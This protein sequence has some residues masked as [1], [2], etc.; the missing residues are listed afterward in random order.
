M[1]NEIDTSKVN[2]R[3][4][5]VTYAEA[6]A[7]KEIA[8]EMDTQVIEPKPEP[9]EIEQGNITLN[10]IALNEL[11]S[12]GKAYPDNAKVYYNPL[13]FGDMKFLSGSNLGV[14]ESMDFFLKHI[15]TNFDKNDITYFDFYYIVVMIKI[16]TYGTSDYNINFKCSK[17]NNNIKKEFS[18]TD[19]EFE[20]L[21][22]PLPATIKREKVLEPEEP[23]Y[24]HFKPLTIG[25]YRQ[26]LDSGLSG[27]YDAYMA[28]QCSN[29]EMDKA[30]E[31]IKEELSGINV[32]MLESI[33]ELFFHG[34]RDIEV[35]CQ[36][37][38]EPEDFNRDDIKEGDFIDKS[39]WEVCGAPH[40]L[41]FQSLAGYVSATAKVQESIRDRIN[42]GL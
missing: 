12:G 29:V 7:A 39:T 37:R 9:K 18:V 10:G 35:V 1:S 36:H 21:K 2:Q 13:T 28:A 34:V 25:K 15:Q 6:Q 17:C 23:E 32:N 26:L 22:V 3:V 33:D 5:P 20:D 40:A 30:L 38:F 41:P 19:L 11:P 24:I 16:S 31:I 27:D 42:F 4:R 8:R 14:T